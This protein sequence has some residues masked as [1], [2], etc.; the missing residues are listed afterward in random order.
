MRFGV[1][2]HSDYY[3]LP[4][5]RW[6]LTLSVVR[7]FR[8]DFPCRDTWKNPTMTAQ[9]RDALALLGSSAAESIIVHAGYL[10]AAQTAAVFRDY[11]S[12]LGGEI[13]A[14]GLA[15]RTTIELWNNVNIRKYWP[16]T[17][18]DFLAFLATIGPAVTEIRARGIRVAG[19]SITLDGADGWEWLEALRPAMPM[20]DAVTVQAYPARPGDFT[21]RMK[22]FRAT[23]PAVPFIIAETGWASGDARQLCG[24]RQLLS[25]IADADIAGPVYLYHLFDSPGFK[26]G[27]GLMRIDAGTATLRS[28]AR[29]LLREYTADELIADAPEDLGCCARDTIWLRVWCWIKSIFRFR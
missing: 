11:L 3:G 24:Y 22:R 15:S 26:D 28:A 27:Y 25:E 20:L 19:F 1:N 18:A 23:Y 29:Y 4:Y 21:D 17:P 16:G 9:L 14:H 8:L 2:V 10:D 6:L 12:F 13:E 5:L 7:S